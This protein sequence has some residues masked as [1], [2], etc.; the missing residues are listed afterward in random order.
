M[1]AQ[2]TRAMGA[3]MRSSLLLYLVL[4]AAPLAAKGEIDVAE[5]GVYSCELPGDASGAAGIR[6]PEVDFRIRSASRYKSD[7]GDGVY[8]RQGDTVRF[9]SGPR[10]GEVWRIVSSKVM[11]KLEPDGSLGRLRCV[12]IGR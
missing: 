8:L 12:R 6:Q 3:P 2:R 10:A 9:T 11:R 7:R 5:R 4:I 1:Q